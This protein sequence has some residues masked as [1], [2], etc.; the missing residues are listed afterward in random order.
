[1]TGY[2]PPGAWGRPNKSQLAR[3]SRYN[4]ARRYAMHRR[5][6]L[7]SIGLLLGGLL[8][9]AALPQSKD[10][11]DQKEAKVTLMVTGMT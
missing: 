9:P 11:K 10:Q 6:A 4:Q 3:Q 7:L 5:G 8:A 1:M 2:S